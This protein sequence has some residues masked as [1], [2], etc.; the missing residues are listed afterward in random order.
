MD[1]IVILKKKTIG[2]KYSHQDPSLG[3]S[4][5]LGLIIEAFKKGLFT[6]QF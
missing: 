2:V 6:R 5:L 1:I 3:E 4:K